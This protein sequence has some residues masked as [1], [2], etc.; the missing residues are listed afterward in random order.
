MC[1]RY[2]TFSHSWFF[3]LSLITFLENLCNKKIQT[4]YSTNAEIVR[5]LMVPDG[6]VGTKFFFVPINPEK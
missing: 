5:E 6:K 3:S 1:K 4:C 2:S